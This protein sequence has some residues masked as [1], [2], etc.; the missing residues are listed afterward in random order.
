MS[1]KDRGNDI[2]NIYYAIF[3]LEIDNPQST[4]SLGSIFMHRKR[5]LLAQSAKHE[6]SRFFFEIYF[7]A[8]KH[9]IHIL[10]CKQSTEL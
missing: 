6:Q 9:R 3:C 2:S 10:T 5:C 1:Q 4:Y 7:F 8:Q